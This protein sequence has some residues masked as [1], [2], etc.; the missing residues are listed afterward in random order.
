MD[1]TEIIQAD[2]SEIN[3]FGDEVDLTVTSPPYIDAIDY[4][5]HSSTGFDEDFRSTETENSDVYDY[6]NAMEDSFQ[7]VYDGTKDGGFCAV[8]IGS[9]KTNDG[10]WYPL[11]HKFASMMLDIGWNF[12]ETITWN[13]VTGGSSRFGVTIQYPY[14]GY[15]YPNQQKE[16]IQVWRRGKITRSKN[17]D[18]KIDVTTDQIKKEVANNVWH[19]APVPPGKEDH[20]CPF[21]EEIA[22]RLISLYSNQGDMVSDPFMGSGTT[23]KVARN[24]HRKVKGTD[25][26]E[27]YVTESRE[28]SKEDLQR[29]DQIVPSFYT[30]SPESIIKQ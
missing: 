21:P 24:L 16:E 12:H 26:L 18:S 20:P 15:Y 7:S 3:T 14:P 11:P 17:E 2:A 10:E 22:Y 27:K 29:R 30:Y 4:E 1:S 6:F 19:I 13:K 28:R 25:I 9:V 5:Q 8:V 23:A